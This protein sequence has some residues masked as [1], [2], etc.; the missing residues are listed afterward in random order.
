MLNSGKYTTP[1]PAKDP[2]KDL[3]SLFER[4]K[5]GENIFRHI[6]PEHFEQLNLHITDDI[7]DIARSER[8]HQLIDTNQYKYL[9]LLQA[10]QDNEFN[11]LAYKNDKS[12]LIL[13]AKKIAVIN[14]FKNDSG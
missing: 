10:Y 11:H 9:Q 2:Y 3:Q 8:I 14:Y 4:Y 7:L 1:Q 12:N 5:E 13:I 6:K